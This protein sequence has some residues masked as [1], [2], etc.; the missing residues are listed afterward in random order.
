[1]INL[2]ICFARSG[3]TLLNRCLGSLPDV[4]IMSEVNP[5]GGGW[6]AE[7]E[8]SLTTIKTQ[9]KKWYD[10]ALKNDDFV[11]SA[12]ELS[13]ICVDRNKKL[14]IR[15]WSFINFTPHKYNNFSPPNKLLSF[16]KLNGEKNI[17][18]FAFVRDAIDV[19]ISRGMPPME[20]FFKQYNNYIQEILKNNIKIFKYED[21]C[22]NPDKE[23]KKI[24]THT[25]IPY[26]ESY[27]NYN[28]FIEVNGDIQNKQKSRGIKYNKIIPL[29][30]KTI[31]IRKIIEI[32]KC[33]KMI[34][35]NK[36][37]GYKTSY[38]TST[39]MKL[40]VWFKNLL[41]ILKKLNGLFKLII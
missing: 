16:E 5:L 4:I 26:N 34:E 17:V 41:L 7:K 2:M 30:R 11:K 28:N 24:C 6:G 36:L 38:Y 15:D 10:I 21:F 12:V 3:G 37:L 20:V 40:K 18:S 1:M 35:I 14:I 33:T 23:I 19:W 27:K 9:A 29:K 31:P 32:N 22:K 25:N 13:D 8:K 39:Q